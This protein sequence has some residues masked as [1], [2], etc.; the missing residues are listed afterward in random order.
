V[1]FSRLY[2]P[3]NPKFWLLVILNL[4]ST[5]ITHILRSQEL[6]LVIALVLAAFALANCLIGIRIALQLLRDSPDAASPKK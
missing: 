3:R 1:K 6:P 5:G 2:Q 4:L